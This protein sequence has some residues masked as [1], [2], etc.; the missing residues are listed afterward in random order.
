MKVSIVIPTKNEKGNIDRLIKMINEV[1]K[2]H[3]I[4][5]EILVIDD[6]SE[7]GSIEDVKELQKSL[8]HL[9]L[10]Q[11][12]QYRHIFPKYPK[13]W[14]YIGLGS[15]HKIGYNLAR[16]DLII[17]MDGDLSNDPKEIPK[18]IRKI[19]EGYDICVG[20]RYIGGG[21]SDK[22]IINQI[23]SRFGNNYITMLSGIK[24]RDFSTGYRAIRR[25]IW[26]KIKD[27]NYTNDNNFLIESLYFA[28]KSGAKISE[29][30]IFFKE[31]EIG[32]SKTPLLKE[33]FKALILPF[34]LKLLYS[35][36]LK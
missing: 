7:D 17:S 6:Q 1:T 3:S 5:N 29:I 23:V 12:A 11:R 27:L 25:N 8:S 16:G 9:K 4:N 10:I 20:S 13:K 18:L 19:N 2:K 24:I 34:K 15:A 32:E 28:Y 31:R 30:P 36:N 22:N 14:K 26:E 21:G 33:T 35:K